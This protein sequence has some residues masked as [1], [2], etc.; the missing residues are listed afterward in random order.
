MIVHKC[1]K[2]SELLSSYS[3][4]MVILWLLLVKLYYLF[5]IFLDNIFTILWQTVQGAAWAATSVFF[6]FVI[7]WSINWLTSG[8]IEKIS[9]TLKPTKTCIYIYI[10]IYILYICILYIYIFT[11]FIYSYIYK[12]RLKMNKWKDLVFILKLLCLTAIFSHNIKK[13]VTIKSVLVIA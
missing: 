5:C 8:N 11:Y 12:I 2:N 3:Q 4:K 7:I 13:R 10:Y 6:N 1:Q 9:L